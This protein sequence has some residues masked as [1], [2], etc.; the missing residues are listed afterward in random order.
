[1]TLRESFATAWQAASIDRSKR[2]MLDGVAF[3][4]RVR[5]RGRARR[6]ATLVEFALVS[7]AIYVLIAAG[8]ELG[9]L[10]F[11]DQV[12]ED[13]VRVAARELSVMSFPADSTLED[14]LADPLVK[15]NVYDADKLVINH[16]AF[17]SEDDF[18]QFLD[19][20][21]V[22]NRALVPLMI[23]D[24]VS[25]GGHELDL[26]RYP[27]AL[28]ADPSSSTGF[29]VH[30]PRIVSRDA[31]GI[32]TIEWVDAL[33]EIRC[34]PCDPLSGPFALTA[35]NP[36]PTCLPP[37]SPRGLVALRMNF[38]FQAGMLSSYRPSPAGP[39]EPN[40]RLPNI[41]DDSQVSVQLSA[42]CP[43]PNGALLDATSQSSDTYSGPYGLGSQSALTQLV[44]PFRKLITT[45]AIYRREVF[46]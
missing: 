35:P 38:P 4:A 30:I 10:I 1:M 45:Q 39:L 11:A 36:P 15:Q 27:G 37:N 14:A 40:L 9:R 31:Q 26:L 25:V 43:P 33:E 16:G 2:A 13:A 29:A 23:A 17:A 7:L 28:W 41:A 5:V 24:R 3:S 32:E 8:I 12:L 18:Q 42:G 22:V 19:T 21:P 44:R 46:Q 6:G 34:A 20:L